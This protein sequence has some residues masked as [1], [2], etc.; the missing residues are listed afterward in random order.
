MK[1][2]GLLVPALYALICLTWGSTWIIIKIGLAGVPPFLAAA[3]RMTLAS[4]AMFA[5][6]YWRG[7]GIRLDRD[8]KIC[9]LSCGFLSFA[10][11]YACVYWAE[12]YISSGLA[13]V[14]YCTMPLATALLSRYW[15]RSETLSGRKVGGIFVAM[16]GTVALF[17]PGQGVSRGQLAGMAV[18]LASV[19]LAAV[20]LVMV[21]RH[22]K[23]TDIFVMNAFGMAIG[24]VVLLALTAF[25]ESHAAV[26]WSRDNILAIVYLALVGSVATFLS[27]YHLVKAMEA[28]KLSLIT[29]IYPIVAVALGRAF[30]HE[31]LPPNAWSGAA[32]VFLG[33]AI[34][35]VP[36]PRRG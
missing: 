34:A 20:N 10:V 2:D 21:K 15:T 11:S 36:A 30:L 1:R 7:T 8:D 4:A 31:R 25:V 3:L 29:L 17:W 24:A 19:F 28:T 6:I 23:N 35:V 13:A 26:A 18:L 16:A 12:Q 9:I 14:L 27:Y 5:L 32:A 33:V 22:G